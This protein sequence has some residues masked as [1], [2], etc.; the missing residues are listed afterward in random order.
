MKM[1]YSKR[2]K[3]AEIQKKYADNFDR[4][5]VSDD[6][7]EEMKEVVRMKCEKA[8]RRRTVYKNAIAIAAC[9]IM[10]VS[11]ANG[12]KI[13]AAVNDIYQRFIGKAEHQFENNASGYE[14]DVNKS[15]QIKDGLNLKIEKMVVL[16]DSVAMKYSLSDNQAQVAISECRLKVD[17]DVYVLN[18]D[19]CQWAGKGFLMSMDF[20]D[21]KKDLSK[22][23]GKKAEV[24]LTVDY[25]KK[26]MVKKIPF[27]VN[28]KKVYQGKTYDLTGEK[29]SVGGLNIDSIQKGLWYMKVEYST[30]DTSVY[31][32]SPILIFE[33]QED[34]L[35]L[36]GDMNSEAIYVDGEKQKPQKIVGTEYV[37]L[38]DDADKF[39]VYYATLKQGKIGK[40]EMFYEKS[41]NYV[42]IDLSKYDRE[43]IK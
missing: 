21:E 19:I 37:Q 42:T 4:I 38:D 13:I 14:I 40:D 32:K 12:N 41:D 7:M 3:N 9:L 27:S 8:Y 39:N 35:W 16:N 10:V 2:N 34:L 31:S 15:L 22:C 1:D 17:Q 28:V 11:I 36:G 33:N 25:G 26:A 30:Y 6:V 20:S 18:Q 5:E 29:V 43:E 23:K 24:E